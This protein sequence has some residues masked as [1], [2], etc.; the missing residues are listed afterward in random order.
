MTTESAI[1][2]TSLLA[3]TDAG[4][5]AL[6]N[7]ARF[8]GITDYET[9]ENALLED[10]DITQRIRAG[11]LVPV[12]I[13]SDG[14]F[15]FLVRIGTASQAPALTSRERQ[16][17][18]VSSQPYL[19]LSDCTARLTGIEHI[20]ADPGP[21]TLALTVPAGPNA[22]TV[23]LIEWDAEPGAKDA[24]GKPASGALPDFVVLISPGG[25]TGNPYRTRLQTFDR[26]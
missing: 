24:H 3:A 8:A 5:H 1:T 12:N 21:A 4:M 25:T 20:C 22:V 2:E 19:Y 23:H 11:E 15:Q 9:W 13:R 14:A 18:L 6:W 16:Y 17:L 7:P 26:D 10:D